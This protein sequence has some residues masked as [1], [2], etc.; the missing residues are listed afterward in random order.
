MSGCVKRLISMQTDGSGALSNGVCHG[1]PLPTSSCSVTCLNELLPRQSYR[2]GGHAARTRI[3]MSIAVYLAA[4]ICLILAADDG[5]GQMSE[6]LELDYCILVS[7]KS[8][9]FMDGE[10]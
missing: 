8:M 10:V 2:L 5:H 9:R 6:I 1:S 4:L 3:L 7:Q